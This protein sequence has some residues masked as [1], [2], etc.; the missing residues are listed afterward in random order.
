MLTLD[1]PQVPLLRLNPVLLLALES[2]L[3]GGDLDVSVTSPS[4]RP[5]T[6]VPA[7]TVVNGT[8]MK[9]Q[10]ATLDLLL[11]SLLGCEHFRRSTVHHTDR[12]GTGGQRS[13]E[14]ENN[15]GDKNSRCG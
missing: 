1:L 9:Q 15:R 12:K 4:L 14:M 2:P 10:T 3:T 13:S 11:L 5:H 6:Q 8:R 7:L